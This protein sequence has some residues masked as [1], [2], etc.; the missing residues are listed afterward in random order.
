MESAFINIYKFLDESIKRNNIEGIKLALE[1][2]KAK[3]FTRAEHI[4]YLRFLYY[5]NGPLHIMQLLDSAWEDL[6]N[7]YYRDRGERDL[8]IRRVR[9]TE[10][11]Y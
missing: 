1:I 11:V 5:T 10:N 2:I 8:M 7:E 3:D 6:Y 9:G 4:R